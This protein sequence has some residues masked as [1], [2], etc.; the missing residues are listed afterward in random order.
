V[1]HAQYVF[2]DNDTAAQRLQLLA[3]IYQDSTRIFLSK[4]AGLYRLPLAL[5]LGCGPGFTT[6]LIGETLPCDPRNW[7]GRIDNVY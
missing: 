7:P 1:S 3:G 6:R 5:D 2:G 4:A